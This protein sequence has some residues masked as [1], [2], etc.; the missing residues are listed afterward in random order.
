MIYETKIKPYVFVICVHAVFLISG[1]LLE[2]TDEIISAEYYGG[3]SFRLGYSGMWPAGFEILSVYNDTGANYRITKT[4]QAGWA[5]SYST[6][7][8]ILHADPEW[9]PGS[10]LPCSI[11]LR[12]K[13]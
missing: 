2:N 1:C 4:K 12:E 6:N 10:V 3:N 7:Y 9:I 11:I 8:I 5:A 13:N